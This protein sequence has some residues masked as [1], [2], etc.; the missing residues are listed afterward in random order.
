MENLFR[1]LVL[2]FLLLKQMVLGLL[3]AIL[4]II[5]PSFGLAILKEADPVSWQLF[6]LSATPPSLAIWI[7]WLISIFWLPIILAFWIL[8]FFFKIKKDRAKI[9]NFVWSSFYTIQIIL[10][11]IILALPIY[12]I[13]LSSGIKSLVA[14][15]V[16]FVNFYLPIIF[17]Y[18]IC[19]IAYFSLRHFIVLKLRELKINNEENKNKFFRIQNLKEILLSLIVIAFV[20]YAAVMIFDI[21]KK[22]TKDKTEEAISRIDNT[23][24]TLD[25]VMGKNLPPKPDQIMNDSTIAGIDS[26]NNVIRDDVEFAIFEKYPNSAKIRAGMFQYAQ[27]LQLELTEVFNSE[28]L[29]KTIQKEGL[30]YR[31]L[32]MVDNKKVDEHELEIES[33]VLNSDLRMKKIENIYKYM[34]TYSLLNDEPC[35]LSLSSLPN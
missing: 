12:Y 34:T 22:L 28:T 23:K 4:F 9:S 21:P 5:S 7:F 29:V 2:F 33:F 15:S 32:N 26:N 17:L 18:L 24:I 13:F 19:F 20:V 1:K 35:D 27:A 8:K 31:C 6:I 10:I 3:V 30:A 16:F 25:D 14:V 11:L